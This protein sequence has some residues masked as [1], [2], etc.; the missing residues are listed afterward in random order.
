MK[1]GRVVS[2]TQSQDCTPEAFR[3]CTEELASSHLLYVYDFVRRGE[4]IQRQGPK[5]RF[6]SHNGKCGKFRDG[7][8]KNSWVWFAMSRARCIAAGPI[9]F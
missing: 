9:C 6:M 4:L 3:Y 8:R 7:S 5:P 1:G 2:T